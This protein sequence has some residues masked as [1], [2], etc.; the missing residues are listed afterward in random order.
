MGPR[1]GS[2]LDKRVEQRHKFREGAILAPGSSRPPGP[3]HEKSRYR[4]GHFRDWIGWARSRLDREPTQFAIDDERFTR[5][6]KTDRPVAGGVARILPRPAVSAISTIAAVA[7]LWHRRGT[8]RVELRLGSVIEGAVVC[9]GLRHGFRF[10]P[11][12]RLHF[13]ISSISLVFHLHIV[14]GDEA[15][16]ECICGHRRRCHA[17]ADFGY[18]AANA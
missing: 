8:S 13:V 1:L 4:N 17:A 6:G 18:L 14:M 11:R 5:G 7:I 2:C 16:V 12:A 10:N 15:G 9:P 3:H